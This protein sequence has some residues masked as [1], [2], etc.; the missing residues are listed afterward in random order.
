MDRLTGD[1]G[2]VDAVHEVVEAQLA[3]AGHRYT[4]GRRLL[5][6]VLLEAGCPITVRE[7]LERTGRMSTS[8]AYRNLG[9][10]EECRIARQI[11]SVGDDGVRVE[12]HEDLVGH[13][14]HLGCSS[15][16]QV[17]DF[18]LP[19]EIE[20]AVALATTVARQATGFLADGHR[21]E[22]VGICRTCQ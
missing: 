2:R 16:G 12:L 13:H 11:P 3:E 1:G 15:C 17:I 6:D 5:V 18:V 19:E 4:R 8:T 10:L 7:L 9:V 20:R 22:L 21:L 14:H